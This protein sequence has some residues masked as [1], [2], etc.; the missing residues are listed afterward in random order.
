MFFDTTVDINTLWTPY[1]YSPGGGQMLIYIY[2]YIYILLITSL[3]ICSVEC[4]NVEAVR[5]IDCFDVMCKES[6]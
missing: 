3:V 5:Q 4:R 1:T 2:I 6:I